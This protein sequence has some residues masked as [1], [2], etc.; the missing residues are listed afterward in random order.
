[1]SINSPIFTTI[2]IDLMDHYQRKIYE[3]LARF[4][5]EA[6][7]DRAY[8]LWL[9]NPFRFVISKA[10]NTKLGDFRKKPSEDL[11]VITIN[12]NL[13]KYSFLL[14]YV[15]EV[16]H[17]WVYEQYQN[18]V[19]PHGVE[20]KNQFKELMEPFLSEEIFPEQVLLKLKA[21]M[22]NPKASSQSDIK[23]AAVLSSFDEHADIKQGI[24][25]NNLKTGST[26]VLEDK[27]FQSIESRRTRVRCKEITTGKHYLVHKLALVIPVSED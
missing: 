6:A 27:T 5:P 3:R 10:R 17:H 2:V 23:L 4:V 7:T 14:T 16:A 1:M 21:H 9:E 15:H 12:E 8:Q 13:N 11:A 26:F 24:A 19:I 22:I 20:W 18:R 25:L